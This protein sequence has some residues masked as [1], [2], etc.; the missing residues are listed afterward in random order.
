[1]AGSMDSTVTSAVVRGR[2]TDVYGQAL[3]DVDVVAGNVKSRTDAA[4][5]FEIEV[6]GGRE[7][8]LS[9]ESETYSGA[10]LPVKVD[11]G[12]ANIE[13]SV[14][15]RTALVLKDAAAGGRVAGADG[16]AVELP[17]S[18]L[19]DA[20]DKRVTGE[21]EVRYALIGNASDV[22]AAPGRMESEDMEGLDGYGFAEVRFYKS[23]K[24]VSL[25]KEITV[26][27]PMHAAHGLNDGDEVDGYE[28]GVTNSRWRKAAKVSVSEG[29]ARLRTSHDEWL[30]AAKALPADSCVAGRLGV[31]KQLDTKATRTAVRAARARGL[32]LVQAEAGED[33]SFCLPVTPND[34][35]SVSTYYDDGDA[36]FGLRVN[37]DSKEATGMCG[38]DGCKQLGDLTLPRL[39]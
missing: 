33:G 14:K 31:G 15:S 29:K 5:R 22:T 7:L 12:A 16:F 32:S 25:D 21:V 30:G 19:R 27:V 6:A 37:V 1:M 36:T 26:E 23:G 11:K 4:G 17:G 20:D 3:K 8:R 9:V 35:W 38:G 13:L 24:R 2:V 10:T 28:L 18:A 39:D 34:E